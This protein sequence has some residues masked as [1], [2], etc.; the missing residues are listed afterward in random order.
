MMV[1]SAA[2]EDTADTNGSHALCRHPSS[3]NSIPQHKLFSSVKSS[4]HLAI[5]AGEHAASTK[6]CNKKDNSAFWSVQC[7][8]G[9]SYQVSI[10]ANA[11]GSTRVMDC[12]L[13]KAVANVSC[14]QKLDEQ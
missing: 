3:P 12:K 6:G 9:K 10:L 4:H 1:L 7:S 13:V 14:F 5:H 8:N 11:T 2:D